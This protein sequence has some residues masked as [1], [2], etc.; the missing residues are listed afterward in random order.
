MPKEHGWAIVGDHGLYIGWQL[1][2]NDAI[3]DHVSAVTGI[4]CHALG[5]RLSR[6]QAQLWKQ[7]KAMGER[8]VKVTISYK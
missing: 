7:R 4:G 1:T 6:E 3:G 2:R 8:A 5:G